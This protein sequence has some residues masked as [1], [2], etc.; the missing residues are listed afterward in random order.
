MRKRQLNLLE[1]QETL[2]AKLGASRLDKNDL[3]SLE[4]ML[5]ICARSITYDKTADVVR[6]VHYTTQQYFTRTKERWFPDV[7]VD[8]AKVCV[9]YLMFDEFRAKT[10]THAIQMAFNGSFQ[11]ANVEW[12]FL[13]LRFISLG[14]PCSRSVHLDTRSG[15]IL[16]VD[17]KC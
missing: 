5:S 6:L 9:T 7:E 10:F 13:S 2:A 15:H 4:D 1:L 11:E 17:F 16:I 12:S 8:F 14:S 3:Y